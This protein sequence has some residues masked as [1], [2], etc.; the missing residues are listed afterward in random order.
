MYH[1]S[2]RFTRS[3]AAPVGQGRSGH[4]PAAPRSTWPG[5]PRFR[6]WHDTSGT[7]G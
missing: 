2:Q 1:I 7:Y 3:A 5:I 6:H 4:A